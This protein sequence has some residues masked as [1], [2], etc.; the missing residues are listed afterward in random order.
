M[1]AM[2]SLSWSFEAL[3]IKLLSPLDSWK[4]GNQEP[5]LVVLEDA[6]VLAQ[7]GCFSCI[8]PDAERKN[9][10]EIRFNETEITKR[11][12]K[13]PTKRTPPKNSPKH[14]CDLLNTKLIAVNFAARWA[15]H[16]SQK[17]T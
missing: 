13:V 15:W 7:A 5:E 16:S 1:I 8:S 6:V 4:P 17:V 12:M 2:I 3:H 9:T 11:S 10:H 14:L